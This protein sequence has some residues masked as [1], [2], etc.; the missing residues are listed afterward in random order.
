MRGFQLRRTKIVALIII[1][2]ALIYEV[3]TLFNDVPDDT[4]SEAMWDIGKNFPIFP[5]V[6]GLI[7][8]TLAGHF[9]WPL[10]DKTRN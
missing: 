10:T 7:K 8:G 3:W 5:W 9:W 2:I 6:L 4:I 1:V